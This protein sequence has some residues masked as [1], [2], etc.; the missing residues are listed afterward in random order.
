MTSLEVISRKS[1]A[2][3]ES[4]S[5]VICSFE[6]LA[7]ESI[8]EFVENPCPLTTPKELKPDRQTAVFE[9]LP[10]KLQNFTKFNGKE[11]KGDGKY[12]I[13]TSD[14]GLTHTVKTTGVQSMKKKGKASLECVL[15]SE[16]VI[17]KGMKNGR[18][19]ERSPKYTMK[20]E[21]KRAE[22]IINAAELT[23]SGDR[24]IHEDSPV[25]EE[26]VLELFAAHSVTVKTEH[27]ASIKV[28]FKAKPMPR[29][30]QFKDGTEVTEE[31]KVVMEKASDA[32]LTIKICV[33]EDSGAIML[34]LKNHC[35]SAS[36]N[37][38]LSFIDSELANQVIQTNQNPSR[39]K[40]SSC[41]TWGKCKMRW[42]TPK[43]SG[44]KQV[45]HFAIERRMAAKKSW[46][47]VGLVESNYTTFAMKKVEERKACFRI[48]AI[49]SE[50]LIRP[51]ETEVFAGE[52]PLRQVSQPQVVDVRKEAVT[53]TNS[54]AQDG[55]S[56]VQGY[57]IEKR[58]KGSNLYVPIT[59]EP[60]QAPP[61]PRFDLTVR[62]KSHMVVCAGTTPCV[63]TSF[64]TDYGV[65]KCDV[66]TATWFTA[67]GKVYSNKYTITG[68]LP[69]RKHFF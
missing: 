34:H 38:Y 19:S 56:P 52:P 4:F 29:V 30:T 48:H 54:P 3:L 33:R 24:T 10:K 36:D 61:A 55:G 17:L 63:H 18:L 59:K 42:K 23:D 20:H 49:K 46:L 6:I 41:N 11:S 8:P 50:G 58:K 15:T 27:I 1:S 14:D 64:P 68:L 57:V 45:T 65:L 53:I 25:V 60:V 2:L 21:G 67:A 16:D 43:G 62:L 9:I 26:S 22:L 44:G 66:S 12:E 39:G 37:P 28:P 5:K 69:G 35:G 51:L 7:G 32:L 40:R 31:E 13:I 47:K